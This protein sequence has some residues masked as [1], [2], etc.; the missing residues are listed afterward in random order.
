MDER[1]SKRKEPKGTCDPRLEALQ[2]DPEDDHLRARCNTEYFGADI[3]YVYLCLNG[4]KVSLHRYLLDAPD[5]AIV[6]HLNGNPLDNRKGNLRITDRKGN[7]RNSG[8]RC[9]SNPYRG[10]SWS[11]VSNKW[12]ANI[13]VDGRQIYLGLHTTP[14]DANRARLLKEKE[15]WGIHPRRRDAFIAA[16]IPLDSPPVP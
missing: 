1:T 2:L 8:K 13:V 3:A 9:D 14:E 12:V 6:D 15:L 10:V 7:A 16:G 4:S 11:K 5:G